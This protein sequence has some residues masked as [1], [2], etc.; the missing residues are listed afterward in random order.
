MNEVHK[1]LTAEVSG[2]I[3]EYRILRKNGGY[4]LALAE[5]YEL[6]L[7]YPYS[8]F[9]HLGNDVPLGNEVLPCSLVDG[10]HSF[11]GYRLVSR[12]EGIYVR[13]IVNLLLE[14][15]VTYLSSV[16]LTHIVFRREIAEGRVQGCRVDD[17]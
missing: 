11:L 7:P 13:V 17:E 10:L 3:E 8:G 12:S 6:I 16:Y 4:L 9:L 2:C 15:V 5:V 1:L 14:C